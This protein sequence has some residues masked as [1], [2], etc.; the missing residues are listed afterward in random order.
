MATYI[1]RFLL[2]LI[3][4]Y[5]GIEKL[6]MPYNPSVFKSDVAMTD[7]KFF[8]FY[9]FLMGTGYLYFVGFFQLLNGLLL[10]FRRTYLLGAVMMIPLMLCLLMT[11]VFISRYVGYIVFDGVMFLMNSFLVFTH[12]TELKTTFLKPQPRLF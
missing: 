1:I 4:I 7:P 5:A 9:D 2:A 3:F 8:D 10:V 11:H 6:F 12:Y